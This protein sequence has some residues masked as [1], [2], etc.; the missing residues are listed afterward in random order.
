MNN[1]GINFRINNLSERLDVEVKNWLNGLKTPDDQAKLAKEI[2]AIANSGG[3][4]IYVG[5]D[6]VG[7]GHP[8]IEPESGEPDAFT[9]DRIVGL[10][11]K[12]V[13]PS[14]QCTVGLFRQDGSRVD[15]PVIT[16]P[17]SHRTPVWAK[18]GS[19]DG[20]KLQQGT[21]YVRRPGGASEPARTQDDWEKLLDR[22]VR[23]RRDEML[24]AVRDVLHPPGNV[25]VPVADLE[26]WDKECLNLWQERTNN[27]QAGDG[28]KHEKGFWTLSF[29]IDPFNSPTLK[30]LRQTL[31]LRLP[32]Y[33]GWPPFTYLHHEPRTPRPIEDKIVAWLAKDH[34]SASFIQDGYLEDFWCVSRDGCGFLL[35]GMEED[36]PHYSRRSPAPSH[37]GYFDWTLPTYRMMEVLKFIEAF[38]AVF[39]SGGSQFQILLRYRGME[40][41]RLSQHSIKYMLP[42]ERT[43]FQEQ[44]ESR[45]EGDIVKIGTAL[46]ELV[47]SLL[48]PVY[49]Q[50]DFAELPQEVVNGVIRDALGNERR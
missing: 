26:K 31:D 42:G 34:S 46:E 20:S 35:R 17:G 48:M 3:G 40:G 28:R 2:I 7:E 50:F 19:P 41:R 47:H 49:E 1:D 44:L 38:A 11:E 39:T 22:L 18:R 27:L 32:A 8:E 16:V 10:I 43:C 29:S 24:D 4:E 37:G 23:A 12:Y 14:F 15:H 33:S 36:G 21:V 45:L 9:Q 5:F 30:E 25:A 6:D 13:I